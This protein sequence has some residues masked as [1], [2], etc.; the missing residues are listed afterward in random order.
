MASAVASPLERQFTTIAGI[1]TMTSSSSDRQHQHHAAVRSRPQHRQRRRRRADGH[2]RRDAAA[3]GEA[4]RRRRR[5]A[6]TTR[7]TS[8]SCMLSLTS[9]TRADAGARRLRRER[10]R[11]ADL[12]GRA[13]SSQVQRA[14]R[15]EVRRPRAGRSR[16]APRAA[17]SAST[18]SIRR[19]R[20]GTSTCRP[21][22]CSAAHRD[23]Q[24][25]GRAAS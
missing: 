22:S 3:A 4:C 1:D 19:C 5:S 13:A 11:A 24:H 17:A 18:K 8:R 6:S 12:D 21:A 16:Q 2:R 25:P 15:A 10:H 14:G 23:V 9:K 7:P 20:T